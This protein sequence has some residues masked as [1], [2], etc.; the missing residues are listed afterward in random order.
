M[1]FRSGWDRGF[2]RGVTSATPCKFAV[3]ILIMGFAALGAYWCPFG[4][5]FIGVAPP[6]ALPAKWGT[7]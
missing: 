7:N 4:A 5:V 1:A 6:P 3:G 2:A